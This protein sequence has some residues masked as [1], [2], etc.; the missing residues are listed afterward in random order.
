MHGSDC[1]YRLR[2]G[3]YRILLLVIAQSFPLEKKQY[4]AR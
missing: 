1:A 4:G 2:Q 3:V